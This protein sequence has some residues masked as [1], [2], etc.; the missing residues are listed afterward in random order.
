MRNPFRREPK[1]RHALGAAVTG[2]PAAPVAMPVPLPVTDVVGGW[3]SAPAPAPAPAPVAPADVAPLP[4]TP[5]APV[6]ETPAPVQSTV[7][8]LPALPALPAQ[9]AD[10]DM[11]LLHLPV[12]GEISAPPAAAPEVPAVLPPAPRLGSTGPRVELGFAD[13]TFRMLDPGSSAAQ[14]LSDLVAELT[15]KGDRPSATAS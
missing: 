9:P 14:A 3:G 1:G 4:V 7:P 12:H 13:G 15:G 10:L 5:V 6:V 8:S 11:A 2:I